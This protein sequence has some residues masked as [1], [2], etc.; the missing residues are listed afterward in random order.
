MASYYGTN[1][2]V[3]IST[4]VTPATALKAEQNGGARRTIQDKYTA[5]GTIAVGSLI[6]LGQIPK[7]AIPLGGS[8]RYSGS[9]TGTLSIGYTGA[10]SALGATT[11]LATTKTQKLYPNL[12]QWGSPLTAAVNVYATLAGHAL[13]TSDIIAFDYDY[14]KE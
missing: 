10:T 5:A 6:F 7:G 14:A 12:T 13:G 4:G 1:A 2:T 8:I 3:L 9:S 11:A